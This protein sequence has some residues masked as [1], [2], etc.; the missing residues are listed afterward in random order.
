MNQFTPTGEESNH[1]AA[2]VFDDLAQAEQAERTL[3]E[4]MSI[5]PHQIDLLVPDTRNQGKR[6]LP[7]T[8]GIW[9]T[10]LRAHAV[11]GV[12][13]ALIGMLAFLVLY[14][15][16]VAVITDNPLLAGLLFLH[17]PTMMGLLA[18]G[19]FTLRPDQAAYLYTARDALKE[20]KHVL[21]VHA[22][23]SDQLAAARRILEQPALKT[24]RT[25]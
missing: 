4:S 19:L 1:K 9:R 2:A 11:F 23:S 14:A 17:V 13:G 21:L 6:L 22:K 3:S 7:E 25:V 20:G 12:A 18:G 5:E 10:W 15:A 16:D 8:K 24:V